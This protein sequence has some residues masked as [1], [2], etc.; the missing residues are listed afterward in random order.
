MEDQAGQIVDVIGVD[1]TMG[2]IVGTPTPGPKN[3]HCQQFQKYGRNLVG[4]FH[5]SPHGKVQ[6]RSGR[7]SD[8]HLADNH[9]H[10]AG[11]LDRG[12]YGMVA[13]ADD[14]LDC[15]QDWRRSNMVR[16]QQRPLR[17][18]SYQDEISTRGS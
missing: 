16:P 6:N 4:T 7:G 17:L 8:R 11:L 12:S 18:Q 3:A 1:E 13:V 9:I 14:T 10:E 5:G 2:G 15:N